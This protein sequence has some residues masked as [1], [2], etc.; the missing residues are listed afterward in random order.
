MM[1]ARAYDL[2]GLLY[3]EEAIEGLKETAALK[4]AV[5]ASNEVLSGLLTEA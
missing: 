2:K 3:S 4:K 1:G 5:S